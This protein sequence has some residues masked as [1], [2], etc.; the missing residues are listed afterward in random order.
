MRLLLPATWRS[1]RRSHLAVPLGAA[2]A[3]VLATLPWQDEGR[4]TP[5]VHAVAVLVA[6]TFACALDDPHADVTAAAPVRE[7]TWAA[8]RVLT[9]AAPA[10]PVL[11]GAV[12]VA[13]TRFDPLPVGVLAAESAGYLLV[14]LAV[15]AGLRAW[16]GT[17][18]PSY[19]AV[20]GLLAVVVLS[21]ALPRSWAMVD[22]QP[23][24]P[25]YDAALW[26]WAG[27]V[28]VAVAVLMRA[29]RDPAARRPGVARIGPLG[30]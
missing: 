20:A 8:A 14:A 25:P 16:R 7:R 6:C 1:V 27:L 19:P 13:R 3:L 29:T 9:T 28:L 23:W 2:V 17:F 26:R 30:P 4:A 22:P 11:V 18:A 15:A 12:L 24:G 21:Y 5:V 10:L